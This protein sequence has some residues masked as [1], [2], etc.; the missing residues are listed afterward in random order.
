MG[1]GIPQETQLRL[2]AAPGPFP[3][4]KMSRGLLSHAHQ[5]YILKN[6]PNG[7]ASKESALKKKESSCNSGDAGDGSSIPGSERSPGVGNGNLLQY[8]WLGNSMDRGT[9]RA[10][11]HAVTKS[12]TRLTTKHTG[13][14][15]KISLIT[16]MSFLLLR[17]DTWKI[18]AHT[19]STQFS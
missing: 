12:W 8:S 10:P 1:N 14:N 2:E 6:F 16:P 19:T 11:V 18:R 9:W 5:I 3:R 13:A 7:S 4:R 17:D 15:T